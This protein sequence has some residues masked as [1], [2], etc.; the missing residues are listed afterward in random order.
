MF[1]IHSRPTWQIAE[2]HATPESIYRN[3]RE[4]LT[5]I[6]VGGLA[7]TGM[8]WASAQDAPVVAAASNP[9]PAHERNP[10]FSDAGR[11]M[12][13][14]KYPLMFNNFYEFSTRKDGP[15]K[16]AKGFSLDPYTL[17]VDGLV[18]K[19][20]TFDIDQIEK[21]G[22]E[23]RVCRFRCVE[24]WAMTVPWAGV[25]LAKLIAQCGV[26]PE[27]KFVAFQTFHDPERA[28]G[29]KDKA[30]TWPYQEGLRIDEA[31]NEMAFVATGLYGKRL[32][33][34]S[35]TPLRIVLPWK[36]GYKGPKSV[37]KMTFVEKQPATMWNTAIPAEYKF[38]SNVDPEVPHPRWSQASEKLLAD[39]VER[40]PTQWY[41]GYG[42]QVASLYAN[43]PR[44]LY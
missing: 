41:N 2:R 6:G 22:Y 27:A 29:Q 9:L 14:E 26:K 24:A 42:E 40:V 1:S 44:E 35:G 5:T 38:Y 10:K 17:E 30:F 13:D 28:P 16:L 34:Q 4:F 33:P 39:V 32:A 43:M 36:Y 25:P 11:A 7:L 18:E 19:P 8:S 23:E 12:T 3:R 31:L 21:L 37:V 20:L 15:A